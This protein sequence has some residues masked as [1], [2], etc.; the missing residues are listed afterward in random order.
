MYDT[1][2]APSASPKL[3]FSTA[4]E[5]LIVAADFAG[6]ASSVRRKV[7]SLAKELRGL[8]IYLKVNVALRL[9][10]YDLIHDIHN[11]GLRC[12]AD[13]KLCDNSETL[14]ADGECLRV[15]RP[16]IVTA[17]CSAGK[18][19]LV[20]LREA[21]PDTEVSGV[22]VL[23][24]LN[25][26]DCKLAY[27]YGVAEA[28]RRLAL[29][30]IKS[31]GLKSIVAAATEAEVLRHKY[32]Q[33]FILNTPAI[34]PRGLKVENDD[35]NPLRITTPTDAIRSGAARV[36]VIVGRPITRASCRRDATMRILD[37]IDKAINSAGQ[38]S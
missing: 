19:A 8:D 2:L 29:I 15:Y 3:D 37:E 21:L 34:R 11:H 18:S 9:C 28:A 22:T 38:G 23:T 6:R 13:L 32:G 31:A 27:D 26:L 24:S 20:S 16:E 10:G 33:D 30:A 4:A 36:R 17:M 1:A 5:R 12:F 7:L 35:Q 25:E 14:A